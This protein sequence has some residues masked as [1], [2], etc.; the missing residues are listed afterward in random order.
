MK[1]HSHDGAKWQSSSHHHYLHRIFCNFLIISEIAKTIGNCNRTSSQ[2]ISASIIY[3]SECAQHFITCL[4]EC[5][6]KLFR[7]FISSTWSNSSS[8]GALIYSFAEEVNTFISGPKSF[9]R[10]KRIRSRERLEVKGSKFFINIICIRRC[11]SQNLEVHYLRGVQTCMQSSTTKK[12]SIHSTKLMSVWSQCTEKLLGHVYLKNETD[13]KMTEV[14]AD[15]GELRS[16]L[17]LSSASDSCWESKRDKPMPL[18]PLLKS[19]STFLL[20]AL[21]K[22]AREFLE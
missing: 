11:G 19:S 8:W 7:S 16:H 1:S 13:S 21:N 18:E 14:N 22:Q 15:Y 5:K 12:P 17:K 10:Y 3:G 20:L 6:E 9:D 4:P 2:N